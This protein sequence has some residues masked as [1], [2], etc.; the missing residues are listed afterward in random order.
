MFLFLRNVILD[1][2]R[3]NLLLVYHKPCILLFYFIRLVCEAYGRENNMF[4]F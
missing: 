1:A 3:R 4:K 2:I